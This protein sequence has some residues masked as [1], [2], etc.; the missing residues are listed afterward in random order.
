MKQDN[1][2]EWAAGHHNNTAAYTFLERYNST[3][4][5]GEDL[6][7]LFPSALQARAIVIFFDSSIFKVYFNLLK[8]NP[9][10]IKTRFAWPEKYKWVKV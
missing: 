10:D 4:F 6:I 1:I 7:N 5:W 8:N 9:N 3:I 2:C